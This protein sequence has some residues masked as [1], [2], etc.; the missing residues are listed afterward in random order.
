MNRLAVGLTLVLLLVPILVRAQDLRISESCDLAKPGGENKDDFLRF[1]H[2]LR[3]ALSK[4][5]AAIMSLLVGYPLAINGEGAPS[6]SVVRVLLQARFEDI[7]PPAIRSAVVD[8]PVDSVWCSYRGIMYGHGQVW[9]EVTKQGRYQISTINLP[10]SEGAPVEGAKLDFV[11]D[12]EEHRVVIDLDTEGTPRYRAWNKPRSL[13]EPPDLE[14]ATGTKD[15][16]GTGPCAHPIWRFEAGESMY[17][18]STG[19]CFADSNPPLP[20]G[21]RGLLEVKVGRKSQSWTCF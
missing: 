8:E 9:V 10:R 17:T 13:T 12:A 11:C 6:R 7:F 2:E 21:Y 4:Q 19:G 3:V 20:Q 5:D 18:L 16:E 1:D 15:Y 14:I